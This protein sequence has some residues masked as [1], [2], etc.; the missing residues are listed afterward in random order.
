VPTSIYHV[1]KVSLGLK[2]K[3]R[4]SADDG[5]GKPGE[6]LG[7]AEKQLKLAD[8]VRIYREEQRAELL[9]LVRESAAGWLA[10]LTG[11][12]AFDHEDRLLGS[13]GLLLKQSL[14]RTTWMFDQPGLGRFTGTERS[15]R[16][17]RA[18]RLLGL[19]DAAGEIA[20]ALVKQHY[21]FERDGEAMFSIEKPKTLEDW[22]RLTVYDD[23]VDRRLVFALAITMEAGR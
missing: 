16:S 12:E 2:R 17:A 1:R 11:Y 19:L 10:A 15:I 14:D 22:Y 20:G 9:V 8:E 3:Y 4:I 5:H 23:T 18:R 21:D 6:S 7:Y 13:F